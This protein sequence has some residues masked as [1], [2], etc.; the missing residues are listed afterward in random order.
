MFREFGETR[1]F[2]LS[3]LVVY[4]VGAWVWF[5]S[6]ITKPQHQTHQRGMFIHTSYSTNLLQQRGRNLF[7]R[8]ITW[9]R[10]A[11]GYRMCGPL[12][13]PEQRPPQP[14][15]LTHFLFLS[16]SLKQLHFSQPSQNG[17][18]LNISEWLFTEP[19]HHKSDGKTSKQQMRLRKTVTPTA[20]KLLDACVN[21]CKKGKWKCVCIPDW[22][23][24][25]LVGV[26]CF[27]THWPISTWATHTLVRWGE[28]GHGP[29]SLLA[30][31]NYWGKRSSHFSSY[32]VPC[33]D[34]W[35]DD[36]G[37]NVKKKV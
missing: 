37:N 29:I 8:K 20:R 28:T 33:W 13:H 31:V 25:G 15:S 23:F 11:L 16:H 14:T 2:H 12:A 17:C 1:T 34:A 30:P 22:N 36:L 4:L 26:L 10:S 7:Q 9:C 21:S 24:I 27:L 18:L 32:N 6:I 3:V 35:M 5:K 19:N